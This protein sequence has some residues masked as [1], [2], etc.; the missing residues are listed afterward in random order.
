MVEN[1]KTA[2]ATPTRFLLDTNAFIALEPFDGHMEPGLGPAATFMRLVMK[3]RNLVF[4]HPATRDELAEGKDQTRATQRIAELDK[5][6]MLA[7]VPISARLL[8]VLGPVVADSNNH[9]D[10]RIL[11]ALQANA[12]N[13]LVTDDI[14]LGKRA[15]RVGL[16]DR[17]L[18]LADA[19]AMLETFEP[20]T[21][22]PP[23]KVTPVES[24]ALDLDQNIFASIRN[25]Y[26]GFDAWIDKVR[27]DSPNRECFIITEDDGTYAAITI[28]KINEPAPECP[29]DL[30][31]P[32]TKISTFK[33][34]PDFGGHRYGE[35][36]LKAVL[37]SHSDHGVGSAY[38]EVWEH[39]QRLIDFMGMFGYS[40]AG[41][42]ARGEIVLAKRY[43]PQ[44]V[45]LSPLD[46]HIAYGPPAISDQAN[47]FVIPIVER[48]HDQLFPECIP[49]TTQLM[50]PGLDGTTHP[51]GNA[52]RKAYLC[53]SSTKQV[54][55]GDAILFYRSGF[56]TVSVVGV[57]EETARSSAPDEVLNLV[58]GRTV[59]GP[60]DIAQLA[61]HSSQVLVILFR[62]DRVVDPEWT[63]TELQNHGVLKAP[64]QTVT[65]V[66][67]AGAQWVHQQL[68]A[69]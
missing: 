42:S 20:A 5:I 55:P 57:V 2:A 54:Q 8:D 37:R 51:W 4:V 49:D 11:A 15:K 29:Y 46:F 35:L 19:V 64:P 9:R 36:L 38:V 47:V 14:P 26:D 67:E 17:I 68:D 62:Q 28:M 66:K 65:K 22:E 43:K 30:P 45:S 63:L 40:D 56:Q 59:Y 23:P 34:E 53:N 10:L 39:H 1:R 61:S 52:L 3:Q 48:W 16:G 69:M 58:G 21:V 60:A 32:V 44:D 6:E 18:T 27:G 12:V 50:L 41:R 7:E 25:D 33:V 24:Y 31:Q 13:F